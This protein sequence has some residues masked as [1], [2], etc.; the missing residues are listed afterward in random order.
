MRETEEKASKTN[1]F[2]KG[3]KA[4]KSRVFNKEGEGGDYNWGLFVCVAKILSNTPY[5]S[6]ISLINIKIAIV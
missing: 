3:G 4:S 2:K 1:E 5:L 6:N